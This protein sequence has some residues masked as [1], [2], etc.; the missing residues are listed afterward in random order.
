MY[1]SSSSRARATLIDVGSDLAS[2]FLS[3][4]IRTP[5]KS[6]TDICQILIDI[7][8][9]KYKGYE[10]V[11]HLMS[12]VSHH[13]R[14]RS[15]FKKLRLP[16]IPTNFHG[17]PR[18][19]QSLFLGSAQYFRQGFTWLTGVPVTQNRIQE[20]WMIWR[21]KYFTSDLLR[22]WFHVECLMSPV[23]PHL[24][25]HISHAHVTSCVSHLIDHF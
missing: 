7:G 15:D 13:R 18:T 3:A 2:L 23:V 20:N 24:I 9:D 8:C 16:K 14:R 17:S 1:T 19:Y 21:C 6:Q 25:S 10:S 4:P 22:E 5:S 11:R 12:H